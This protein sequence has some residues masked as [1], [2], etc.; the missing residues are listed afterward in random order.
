MSRPSRVNSWSCR[1]ASSPS[2]MHLE[3][4][5][6]VRDR[7]LL[8]G[9]HHG[10]RPARTSRACAQPGVDRRPPRLRVADRVAAGQ[11]HPVDHP[12]GDGGLAG[13]RE[14]RGLV[15]AG[16]EVAERVAVAV[17]W[18][19][20]RGSAARRRRAARRCAAASATAW[21]ARRTGA[22]AP[23]RPR[24][25]LTQPGRLADPGD[26]EAESRRRGPA[27]RRTRAGRRCPRRRAGER[28]D[29]AVARGRCRRAPADEAPRARAGRCPCGP[30]RRTRADEE[31][32]DQRDD[33]DADAHPEQDGRRSMSNSRC[34]R[35]RPAR[36]RTRA[37]G[38]RPGTRRRRTLRMK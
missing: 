36:R 3:A 15:A 13:R 24:T 14:D 31:Q 34:P 8:A 29:Q 12:V 20:A 1:I 38:S 2:W 33:A 11:A 30:W 23:N 35:R 21:P 5:A 10:G 6:G 37:S 16:G 28:G 27:R 25:R 7:A 26:V 19:A 18:R 9:A 4:G 32:G 17:A 22:I